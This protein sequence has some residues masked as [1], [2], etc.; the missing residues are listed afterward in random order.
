MRIAAMDIETDALDATKIHV[1]CAKDVDTKEKYE[2]L[3]VCTVVEERERF[4]EFCSV[5]DR[6]V[7]HNG[8]GFDVRVINKLVQPDL[9]NPAHVIDTLIMSRLIDYGI[10]GGHSLKAWGQRIGEF[11]IGF[12]QFEVLTQEMI[13]YCHQDVEV[14]SLLYNRFKQ[15]IFDPDWADSVRCEH[16]IQI[17]CE[18]MTAHGFY[19]D[20][21]RAEHLLDDIELRMFVLTD[22]FQ[23]DFPPQLEEVNR[24]KYRKKKDGSVTTTVVRAREKY[25]KTV[26]DWSVNPPDV[27]C[28]ELIPFNPASSKMRIERLWDAGWTPYE[29]TKGHITYDREKNKRSWR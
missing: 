26:V 22:S 9:I 14:T 13:T 8:I 5:V 11:K 28:Y 2:F 18:E 15:T 27:V 21:D 6:F 24:L 23:D 7:F 10:Q 17:L 29:K 3:N 1:I 25:P 12:D 4:V 16:D 19:F 20:R